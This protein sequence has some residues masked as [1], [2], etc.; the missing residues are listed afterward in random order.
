MEER[1]G[2]LSKRTSAALMS[3]SRSVR[4]EGGDDNSSSTCSVQ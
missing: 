3:V 2:R 1:K 4:K